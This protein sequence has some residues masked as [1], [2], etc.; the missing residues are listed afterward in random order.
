MYLYKIFIYLNKGVILLKIKRSIILLILI[1]VLSACGTK[2]DNEDLTEVDDDNFNE[3]DM[4]IVDEPVSYKFLT[5]NNSLRASDWNDVEM[6]Q[7]YEDMSNVEI[8]WGLVP[9][10]GLEEKRSLALTGGDYPDAFFNTGMPATELNEYGTHGSFIK[11]NDLIEEY[12]P[13][14]Q[15]LM[16][17]DPTIRKGLTFPDGNIYSLPHIKAPDFETMLSTYKPFVRQDWL[18][19]LDMDMPE[20]TDDYYEFLK[21]AKEEIDS[22]GGEVVPYADARNGEGLLGWLKGAFGLGNRGMQHEFVDVDPETDELR[23]FQTSDDNKKMLEYAHKLYSEGLILENIFSI[24]TPEVTAMGQEGRIA[25]TV[26]TSVDNTY[27]MTGDEYVGAPQL[28]GPDGYKMWTGKLS[29]L[30]SKGNFVITDKA[31]N[32]AILVRWIDYFYSDEGS[33]L[34]NMGI[35]DVT[36][37]K[38]DDGTNSWT[39]EMDN[40]PNGETLIQGLKPYVTAPLGGGH[41]TVEKETTFQGGQTVERSMEAMD[42]LEP[43]AIEEVWAPFNF[44]NDEEKKLAPLQDDI[45]KYVNEMKVKFITGDEPLSGWDDYTKQLDDLKLDEYMEIQEAAYDRYQED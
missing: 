41:P 33:L 12:M 19:E 3:E 43:D 45:Q 7:I 39:E 35:E 32:P 31:E 25:S 16:D 29:P 8:D 30:T 18:D 37:E 42:K 1:V 5:S 22:D 24:D 13:N 34:M 6:W 26:D 20:N 2:E 38:N 40:N 28:E 44:T 14:L 17:D 23:F 4:P 10:D 15:G 27:G 36:Y 9:S 21:A 11:L